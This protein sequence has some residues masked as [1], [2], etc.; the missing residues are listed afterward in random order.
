M[1]AEKS[2]EFRMTFEDIVPFLGI[3]VI[4]AAIRAL[5]LTNTLAYDECQ[6]FL[7]ANS[8]TLEDFLREFRFR[9]H[10][11]LP[12]LPMMVCFWFG[13]SAF[14]VKFA[15]FVAGMLVVTVAYW[16]VLFE[17]KSKGAAFL[18]GLI[19]SSLPVLVSQ[20]VEAR[21]YSLCILFVWLSTLAALRIARDPKADWSRHG[22]LALFMFL[23]VLSEYTAMVPAAAIAMTLYVPLLFAAVRGG[24]VG[25]FLWVASPYSLMLVLV[26]TLFVWQ[27]HDRATSFGHADSHYYHGRLTDVVAIGSFFAR[28]FDSFLGGILPRPLGYGVFALLLVGVYRGLRSRGEDSAGLRTLA[29]ASI[30]G[31]GVLFVGSLVKKLPFGGF[32]RHSSPLLPLVFLGSYL[33]ACRLLSGLSRTPRRQGALAVSGVGLCLVVGVVLSVG[34]DRRIPTSP[35]LRAAIDEFRAS[36]GPVI[37]NWRGRSLA[38]WWML[39][40]RRG[41]LTDEDDDLYEFDYD[42]IPVVENRRGP[43]FVRESFLETADRF[44]EEYGDCWAFYGFSSRKKR[45]HHLEFLKSEIESHP[46][47]GLRSTAMGLGARLLVVRVQREFPQSPGPAVEAPSE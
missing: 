28:G 22:T 27:F 24:H 11:P 21:G 17:V 9:P 39:N 23:A 31:V 40:D 14:A 13:T 25:R 15:A 18:A 7:I 4:A 6:H 3:V 34:E 46:R 29:I 43:D 36:P 19:A 35:R 26:G 8:A 44:L 30:L 2:I 12:Y 10:P 37:S 1:R 38:S 45:A 47:M 32:P 5:C 16:S 33:T 41:P 42:G 20:S